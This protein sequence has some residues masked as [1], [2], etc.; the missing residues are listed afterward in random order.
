MCEGCSALL[1]ALPERCYKCHKLSPGFKTCESC[2]SNSAL[3]RVQFVTSYT[4][5][6][7]DLVWKLKFAHAKAAVKPM[8]RVMVNRLVFDENTLLTH[9]PTATS[10]I[11]QR[12]Y[13]QA[14]LLT[15]VLAEQTSIQAVDGLG[16]M[17]QERQVGANRKERLEH[18]RQAFWVKHP[19]QILNKHIVLVDDV[20][21][22][23]STL[24]AAAT[25]L[26]QAGAKRVSAVI[27]AQA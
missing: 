15:S 20:L 9:V 13:D 2:R 16:R 12:G 5:A 1:Q 4:D 23:G 19:D 10:R 21:T 7:K 17:G 26:R 11:R 27:F 18:L 24:E 3:Y 6:A 22:T 8:G 25:V 14:Q